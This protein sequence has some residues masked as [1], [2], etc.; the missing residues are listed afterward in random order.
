MRLTESG[1]IYLSKAENNFI[2]P[3]GRGRSCSLENCM[4]LGNLRSEVCLE[5]ECSRG[6]QKVPGRENCKNP[7]TCPQSLLG[8]SLTTSQWMMLCMTHNPI[9]NS[10]TTSGE[11]STR[12]AA[13]TLL[14]PIIISSPLPS[15]E[16]HMQ[17]I[18]PEDETR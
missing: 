5:D 12:P 10:S 2:F 8:K 4:M 7:S 3:C 16:T 11:T 13:A 18:S 14:R 6:C 1:N 17:P 9:R 15:T